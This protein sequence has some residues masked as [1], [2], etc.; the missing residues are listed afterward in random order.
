LPQALLDQ[1]VER[2]DG[3]PLFVEEL[4]K[5]VLESEQVREDSGRYV[6]DQPAQ[7]LAIPTTL[8]DSL[9]ARVDRLGSS[10]EVL[11][12]GAAIGREFSYELLAA[13][14][15]LPD[16]VLQDALAR[17]TE[18]E[19]L[20]LRG[21]P[22]DAVYAFKHALVQDTS[23][24]TMLRA[25]R[26]QL[27][28]A[29]AQV[30]EKR[31]PDLVISTP[32]V[33]AQ[34]FEG[35]GRSEQAIRYWRQAGDRDL[36]RFAMKEA[37][38]HYS[39]AMRVVSSLPE[40][41]ARAEQQLATHLAL[42][43]AQQI[44]LG[45]AT[46]ESGAHYEQALAIS[47][48]LNKVDRERF[49][50]TWG[51]WFYCAM[52]GRTAESYRHA[53]NL[54]S[55][56]RELDDPDLLLEA[57]HARIPGLQRRA[58]FPEIKEA[59]EEV[60]RRYSRERHR[61][62]GYF[63]GGHDARVC[64]QSFCCLALWGLG[65]FDQ[66]AQMGKQSIDDARDLGHAYS[67]A[68]AMHQTSG[69]FMLLDDVNMCQSIADELYPIAERN[70]F[71]WPLACARFLRGWLMT[72]Q[73]DPDGGIAQMQEAVNDP[74]VLNRLPT[75]L[76][77]VAECQIRAGHHQDALRTLDRATKAI[78]SMQARFCEPEIARLRGDVFVQ[79]SRSNVRD[80]ETAFRQAIAT[81]HQ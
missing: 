53:D 37:I 23:Y 11:Q 36:R 52:T 13:V 32:E 49:L 41:R 22:P 62:H 5:A 59:C 56:A 27:H 79:Q 61:D 60:I 65:L 73:G 50:A 67:I 15:G 46:K 55:I 38:S 10:R 63:F 4:T 1:I 8:Q 34:Q 26:Q 18:A 70:K 58:H 75:L 17:L 40:S 64:A 24:S 29:I 25:R 44:A 14:A 21:T 43:L 39:N 57:F 6:L 80:A 20:F 42:G 28:G 3:V 9:M 74:A 81:A 71:P 47:Q 76:A 33:I 69:I 7:Q 45:P 30:L 31:F 16:A 78:T 48:S 77:L 72:R 35:A 51:I 19:L 66:A 68:H 12:I 2:T 54:V